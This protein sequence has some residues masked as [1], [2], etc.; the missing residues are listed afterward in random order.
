MTIH[1][2]EFNKDDPLLKVTEIASA[3][4]VSKMTVYRLIHLNEL[5]SVQ[6]GRA[7]RVRESEVHKYLR[8]A[9]VAEVDG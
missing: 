8:R 2:L 5:P 9:A 1:L 7:Y 3:L 6:I 4:R